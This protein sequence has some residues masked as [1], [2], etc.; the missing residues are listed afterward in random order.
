MH[1]SR[2]LLSLF[3]LSVFAAPASAQQSARADFGTIAIQVRPA[4]ADVMIDGERW[5]SS[6]SDGRI[7][8]QLP[9]GR[10]SVEI[11]AAGYIPFSTTLDVRRGDT[12]PLNVSLSASAGAPPRTPST[13]R[14]AAVMPS[15]G[16][17]G[18]AIAPDY[19]IGELQHETAQFAG[20]Y[21]GRVF[22]GQFMIGAG[23]YWQT[24]PHL[25][26]MVY[27]GP[28]VEWRVWTDRTI[29]FA[30][31]A[32]AGYGQAHFDR[33]YM[34]DGRVL[35]THTMQTLNDMF[36]RGMMD[37]LR[38]LGSMRDAGMLRDRSF[39]VAEPEAQ[40]IAR[41]GHSI[42]LHAG[43]GYRVTSANDGMGLNGVSG[44][45]SIQFGR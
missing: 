1:I 12:S 37:D 16:D 32:L 35:D 42:S 20:V 4:T 41:F 33:R 36:G 26:R 31:H 6:E 24:N 45:L 8:V 25:T 19:R 7:V 43:V 10:H 22:D 34:F 23:A 27:G 11:R 14:R 2:A 29:G 9:E 17:N 40:V 5:V 44:S 13:S 28:V 15:S 18:W 21:G 3:L 38:D 39:F 30:A